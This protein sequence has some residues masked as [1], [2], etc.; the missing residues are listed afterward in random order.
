MTT[1]PSTRSKRALVMA[2]G[3]GGHIFPALAV[4][5]QLQAQGWDVSWLGTPG[6]MESQI[7]PRHGIAVQAIDF[8][9]V[10]GKG[11]K[12]LL[13]LPLRLLKAFAQSWSIVGR[14]QPD[15]VLGF[16]G[17]VT[18]P[19]AMMA[20][21]RGKPLVLHEQNAVAGMANRWLAPIADRIFTA[22]P[23]AFAGH[24]R[25]QWVG[26]PLRADFLRQATPSA[27]LANRTGPLRLLVVGGSLGAKALNDTVP[28]A[29]ALMPEAQRPVVTHQSGAKNLDGLERNYAEAGVE[30]TLV[31][32][33][34]NMAQALADADLI[35]CRSGASTVTEIAAVGA[36]AIYV[37]FPAAV[38]DHQTRNAEFL[39]Q[40][41][42]GWL[43]PQSQMKPDVLAKLLLNME[44]QDI[45][46]KA[47]AAKSMQKITAT[48][49]VVRAC[50]EL[51][52]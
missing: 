26:N 37:P 7:V 17:Y 3:T 34:D 12:T 30:A 33:I 36:A 46:Q 32:F 40:A 14:V 8:S 50:E 2:G 28:K 6:S 51:S 4:A 9:G 27:R 18:F 16:G 20:V 45:V 13:L 44:R 47:D 15:V 35:L 49:E 31:P 38:D 22:F 24:K 1:Q 23:S 41:G 10:R 43:L 48:D 25:A 39:V 19:G 42:G 29:L 21:L 5:Q 52:A 11:L